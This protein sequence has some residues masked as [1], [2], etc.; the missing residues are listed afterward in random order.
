M[1]DNVDAMDA[2]FRA[3][4]DDYI[5]QQGPAPQQLQKEGKGFVVASIGQVVGPV[6]F[7][8]LCA[9]RQWLNSDMAKAFLRAYQAAMV[10]VIESPAA[11]IAEQEMAANF[12][13]GIAPKVLVNTI[14]DYQALGCWEKD[15]RISEASFEHLQDVF[16]YNELIAQRYR[17]DQVIVRG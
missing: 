6:A 10:Y 1:P 17:Y 16:L 13:P 9:T 4:E 14:A 12:F 7:S 8:S 2:A 11:D 5:H 3:G 15:T